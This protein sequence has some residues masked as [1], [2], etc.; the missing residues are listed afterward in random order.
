MNEHSLETIEY[1]MSV[2]VR[3]I[4][5][6]EKKNEN[7]DRSAYLLLRQLYTQG[8]SGVKT[9]ANKSQLNISTISR[10]AAALEQ[11]GYVDKIPHSQDGRAYYY[12]IT[13]LGTKELLENKQVRNDR[14]K[15]L[16]REW[17]DEECQIFGD[18]LKK[19]NQTVNG[20]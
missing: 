6:T 11:K 16:L 17:P 15:N 18:L 1:E 13:D 20:K 10:Q 4:I 7:L 3:R 19:Y 5:L 12:Q 8:P 2:F 14:I 9:L